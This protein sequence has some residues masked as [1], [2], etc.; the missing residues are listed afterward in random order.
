MKYWLYIALG[1]SIGACLRYGL[2]LLLNP[3][4]SYFPMGT[5]ACNIMG[6]FLLGFLPN[7]FHHL[8]A[9]IRG[10]ITVGILGA[11]TT[12]STF[13]NESSKLWVHDFKLNSLLYTVSSLLLGGL[14]LYLGARTA[15]Y[16]TN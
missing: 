6:C 8:P 4:F 14:F 1:G 7:Y 12:F 11:F 2:Q 3:I 5:F 13:I 10:M 15:E 16:L 9:E